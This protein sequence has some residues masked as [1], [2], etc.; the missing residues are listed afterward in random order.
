MSL[1]QMSSIAQM[2]IRMRK[3][4]RLNVAI[5]IKIITR[6]K[7]SVAQ[8]SCTYEIS[9]RGAR[10]KQ[11]IGLAV[12]QDIWVQRHTRRA[13]FRVVWIGSPNTAESGQMGVECL[14]EKPLWEDEIQGRLA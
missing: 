11:V 14:D 1:N 9:R 10:L 13:K 4:E 3:E 5:P 8:W 6:E 7:S 2:L 12:G